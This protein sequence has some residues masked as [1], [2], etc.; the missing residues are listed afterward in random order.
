MFIVLSHINMK[1]QRKE[2]N[3]YR[4]QQYIQDVIVECS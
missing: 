4:Y 2:Y 1:L 3:N